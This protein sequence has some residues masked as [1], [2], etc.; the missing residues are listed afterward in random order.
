V[1]HATAAAL[2]G[3]AFGQDLARVSVDGRPQEFTIA[4]NVQVYF[5]DRRD[6]WQRGSNE[7]TNGLVRHF[8]LAVWLA[9]KVGGYRQRA[10][11]S[12]S[13]APSFPPTFP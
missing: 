10:M 7:N 12:P 13:F 3:G 4:T 8:E 5:Y 2:A 1:G 9:N 6:P 11:K